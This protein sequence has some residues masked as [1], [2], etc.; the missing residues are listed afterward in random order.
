VKLRKELIVT[1][2]NTDEADT[3]TNYELQKLELKRMNGELTLLNKIND[4]LGQISA[5]DYGYC[6]DTG[7]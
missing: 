5:G 4:S 1:D 6:Q 3:A 7:E 2:K